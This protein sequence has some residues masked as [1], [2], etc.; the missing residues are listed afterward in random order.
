MLKGAFTYS[1]PCKQV[2]KAAKTIV[3]N[4]ETSVC[5]FARA[6]KAWW[7]HVTVAPELNKIKVFVRG[8]V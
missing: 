5:F 1:N 4:R 8:I 3:K 2:N 6:N 7:D